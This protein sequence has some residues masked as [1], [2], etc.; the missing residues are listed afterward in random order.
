MSHQFDTGF[1]VRT[2]AWHGLGRVLADHPD[3]WAEARQAADLLWEPAEDVI[4]RRV[5]IDL[6]SAPAGSYATPD[7]DVCMVPL[8]EHKLIKRDDTGAELSVQRT[9]YPI[10]NHATMGD[11]IEA[12]GTEAGA[13]LH[14]D[15]VGSLQGGRK[16]YA[17]ALLDEPFQV[18]GDTSPT[19]PY[20]AMQNAHDGEGACRIIPTQVR[21][22]CMNTWQLAS[23]YASYEVVIRHQGNVAERVEAAKTGLRQVRA[24]A[25]AYRT[26]M[27]E[28]AGL[29]YDDAVLAMFLERFIPTPEGATD[30]LQA[31]RAE[32]RNLCRAMLAES[33]TLAE[34]PP[35]AYQLVQLVG[36]YTDHLRKLPTTDDVARQE[37]YLRRTM[38]GHG[39]GAKTKGLV[40]DLARTLCTPTPTNVVQLAGV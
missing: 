38:L 12:V 11:L 2:P 16:V 28:L 22:V 34:L 40:I 7:P 35:T 19:Y 8:A 30:R 5:R 21:I 37:I 14:F 10:I 27:T 26:T 13:T 9:D 36:E 25:A 32:R 17:V 4:Y 31:E 1:T 20:L 3:S 24:A 18:P 33:P 29:R 6:A 15:S 23:E 39:E